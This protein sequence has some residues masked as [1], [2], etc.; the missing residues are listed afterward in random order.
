MQK[1]LLTKIYRKAVYKKIQ[2]PVLIYDQ[3]SKQRKYR[4]SQKYIIKQLDKKDLERLDPHL[5]K[6]KKPYQDF[7]DRGCVSFGAINP[8]DNQVIALMCSAGE[9]FYDNYYLQ[10]TFRLQPHQIYI[11]AGE[12]APAFRHTAIAILTLKATWNYWLE[13]G[14][15]EMLVSIEINN[16]ASLRFHF[17]VGFREVGKIIKRHRLFGISW[18]SVS[19]YSGEL[20]SKYHRPATQMQSVS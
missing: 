16:A 14:K 2:L 19:H 13:Q 10:Y 7:I 17:H 6:Y 11:F 9:D 4:P 5:E 3:T 20:L 8:K 15:T 12:I 1:N 18:N